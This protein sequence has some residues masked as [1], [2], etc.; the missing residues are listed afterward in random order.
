MSLNPYIWPKISV[1][2]ID[3]NIL[4][5]RVQSN[6]QKCNVDTPFAGSSKHVTKQVATRVVESLETAAQ[7]GSQSIQIQRSLVRSVPDIPATN[8]PATGIQVPVTSIP[9]PVPSIPVLVTGI[10]PVSVTESPTNISIP[11]DLTTDKN[12]V[13]LELVEQQMETEKSQETTENVVIMDD[14]D[15]TTQINQPQPTISENCSSQGLNL[16]DVFATVLMDSSSYSGEVQET[17]EIS[18]TASVNEEDL[19]VDNG[20]DSDGGTDV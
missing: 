3:F 7:S 1:V 11:V 4:L 16:E 2:L 19:D 10:I 13:N 5:V 20:Q 8:I 15:G 18:D 12:S 9:V 14:S 6:V 17:N